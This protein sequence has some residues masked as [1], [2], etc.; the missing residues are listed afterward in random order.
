MKQIFPIAA[1]LLIAGSAFFGCSP[2]MSDASSVPVPDSTMVELLI[3][4]HLA[5][6]R[7]DILGSDETAIR[8]SILLQYDVSPEAFETAVQYYTENPDA[9]LNIYTRALDKLSD[10]R[11]LPAPQR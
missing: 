5:E 6:A 9:Y 3:E 7:K 1:L 8:D 11:Y 2:G 10:E 4:L